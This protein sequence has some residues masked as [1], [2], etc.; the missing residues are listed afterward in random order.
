MQAFEEFRLLVGG[1]AEEHHDAIAEHHGEPGLADPHRERRARQDL[2]LEA[3][4]IDAVAD[5]QRM[6]GDLTG[7]LIRRRH[8]LE[9]SIR[10]TAFR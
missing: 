8:G 7:S 9:V 6:H 1:Q 3:R 10:W 4:R 5:L 2:A